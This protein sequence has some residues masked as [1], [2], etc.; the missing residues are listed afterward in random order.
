MRERFIGE[1]SEQ[2]LLGSLL[3]NPESFDDIREVVSKADFRDEFHQLLF[4]ACE[5]IICESRPLDVMTAFQQ[6]TE[7]GYR[8]DISYVG[9]LAK[10]ASASRRSAVAYARMV[11][12][13]SLKRKLINASDQIKALI[14][15]PG[16][17]QSKL[18]Q[19]SSFF[20][21]LMGNDTTGISHAKEIL[22][23]SF[24]PEIENRFNNRGLL[25][26]LATG[27]VDIDSRFNGLRAP[28]LIILAGRPSMGKT[29]FA[30]NI[31][32][33]VTLNQNKNALVFSMEMG[34]DQ[35]IERSMASIGGI[36]FTEIRDGTAL[37][38]DNYQL[39][40]IAASKLAESGMYIDD[41]PGLSIG[42]LCAR[43]R[44]F[45]RRHTLGLV[46]VDYLQL[47]RGEGSN[48]EQEIASIS[49]ALKGLAKELHIPV[50]CLSQLNRSLESRTDKRPQMSDL[51]ESGAIEQDADI[52]SFLYRDEVYDE[53]SA[54]KGIAEVITRKFRNGQTGTDYLSS[55]LDICAFR[56]LAHRDFEPEAPKKSAGFQYGNDVGF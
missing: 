24:L 41:S 39:V 40:T 4:A 56:N 1:S 21:E 15:L 46:A 18:E 47:I 53:E 35:L 11:S 36:P 14:D 44:R 17:A 9:E 5:T 16:T 30:M 45:H 3:T 33:H 55:R 51:R 54:H 43:A 7:M 20:T 2:A 34:K 19:V 52:I 32:E 31:V 13:A 42:E 29:T 50:I 6:V 48:R 10:N 12:D 27:Y 49:R 28:D 22:K 23:N 8:P 38:N 26:G 37:G 25:Q